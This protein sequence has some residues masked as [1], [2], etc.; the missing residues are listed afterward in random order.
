MRRHPRSQ[1]RTLIF[2]A[3][4]R[5]FF[6][7][8]PAL[9]TN[10]SSVTW[11]LAST[12]PLWWALKP[13]TQVILWHVEMILACLTWQII[14]CMKAPIEPWSRF[15]FAWI[16]LALR[17][18]CQTVEFLSAYFWTRTLS[19]RLTTLFLDKRVKISWSFSLVFVV[20]I[21]KYPLIKSWRRTKFCPQSYQYCINIR[22]WVT[23]FTKREAGV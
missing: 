20:N 17:N 11:G 2:H 9:H 5:R 12:N 22:P 6:K 8:W 21:G 19:S 15:P 13:F 14:C 4:L 16:D 1:V 3:R 10:P 18:Q 7:P 23:S